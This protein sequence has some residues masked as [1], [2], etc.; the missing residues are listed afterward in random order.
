MEEMKLF[1]NQGHI[2]HGFVIEKKASESMTQRMIMG[3][4]HITSS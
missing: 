2:R 1:M 4:A 3:L